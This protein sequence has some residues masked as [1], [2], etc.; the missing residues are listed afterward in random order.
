MPVSNC[1]KM[2]EI[3]SVIGGK[4]KSHWEVGKNDYFILLEKD[5]YKLA[6]YYICIIFVSCTFQEIKN[7]F[8][9]T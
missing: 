4:K 8:R 9:K 5:A 3:R 2:Q 6:M 1:E 7:R